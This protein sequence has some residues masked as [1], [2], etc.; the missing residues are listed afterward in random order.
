METQENVSTG[1]GQY[2]LPGASFLPSLDQQ[3]T[4]SLLLQSKCCTQPD[5]LDLLEIWTV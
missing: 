1:L 3:P 5:T 2:T 4:F